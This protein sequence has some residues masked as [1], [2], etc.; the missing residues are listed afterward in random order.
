MNINLNE[1]DKTIISYVKG[2]LE[3]DKENKNN[4]YLNDLQSLLQNL[5]ILSQLSQYQSDD[6]KRLLQLITQLH[7]INTHDTHGT[8]DSGNSGEDILLFFYK[9][10]CIPSSKFV[11][12]WKIIKETV[13]KKY[14]MYAINCENSKYSKYCSELNVYEYPTIKYIENKKIHNYY[15]NLEAIEIIKTFNLQKAIK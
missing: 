13:S 10:N 2:S 4:N 7:N 12:E 8:N 3:L 6:D 11:N 14:K 5:V 15:G 9:N 1:Y